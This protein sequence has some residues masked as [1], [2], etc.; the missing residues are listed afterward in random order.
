MTSNVVA[1]ITEFSWALIQMILA[2]SRLHLWRTYF[3]LE[4]FAQITLS[5]FESL[6][7]DAIFKNTRS[8]YLFSDLFDCV[9]CCDR[10][11]LGHS[12][13]VSSGLFFL[14]AILNFESELIVCQFFLLRV[15]DIVLKV[16]VMV[17]YMHDSLQTQISVTVIFLFRLDLLQFLLVLNL[18]HKRLVIFVQISKLVVHDLAVFL[19]GSF[20]WSV[21]QSHLCLVTLF[22][23]GLTLWVD[24]FFGEPNHVWDTLRE[25]M[26]GV[27]THD[28]NFLLGLIE[29][30]LVVFVH[31]FL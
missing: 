13:V 3:R 27:L 23:W 21:G 8:G 2:F 24:R 28:Y 26:F 7:I 29:S 17:G 20:T 31:G 18:L 11:R 4:F 6:K 10:G 1:G 16:I 9:S 22:L 25:H 15:V 5:L 12:Q 14:F 19:L 30:L